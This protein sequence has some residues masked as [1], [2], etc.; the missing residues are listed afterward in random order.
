MIIRQFY[1]RLYTIPELF[2]RRSSSKNA[3]AHYTWLL[4]PHL[5]VN[6]ELLRSISFKFVPVKLMLRVY[7]F[8]IGKGVLIMLAATILFVPHFSP[9]TNIL[10]SV[11]TGMNFALFSTGTVVKPIEAELS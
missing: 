2:G 5:R 10:A 7:C 4:T 3:R 11:R 9:P 8:E 6:V 1:S